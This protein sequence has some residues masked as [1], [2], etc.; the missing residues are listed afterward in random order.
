MIISENSN[1]NSN[2]SFTRRVLIICG[3]VTLIILLVFGAIYVIDVLLLFFGAVL[4]SIFLHGLANI[5][6]RYL[7]LSEGTSVLLV[8][9]LLVAAIA[10]GVWLLAPSVA[11]QVKHL[12]DELPSSARKASDF[13]SN[14]GWGRAVLE[15]L[16]SNDE[17][18]EK[19]ND[20]T[21]LSRVGGYFSSTLGALTN[22]S[23]MLLLSIHY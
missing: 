2:Q 8:S 5:A 15:Q 1:Q 12:R 23:L 11:E 14:Y 10:L 16:P 9:A 6:R 13:L 20:S 17:I 22:L 18:F 21:V 3:I 4:L 19:V 7:R